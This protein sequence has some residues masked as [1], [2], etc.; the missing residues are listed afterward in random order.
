[1]L[2][3]RVPD[4]SLPREALVQRVTDGLSGR[5]V[6][7]VAGAG[8][9]KSTLLA[10]ALEGSPHPWVWLGCDERMGD[11]GVFVSHIAAGIEQR[12]PG[13]GAQ[14][15]SAGPPAALVAA[16]GNEILAT[17][18]EDLI[19]A[20][21]DAHLLR[22]TPGYEVLSLL[23]HDL[24][25]H[26][27]LAIA[28]RS[29]LLLPLA[30]M[31][32]AD[33]VREFKE[34]DLVLTSDESRDLLHTRGVDLS[35]AA[36]RQL[37]KRTE[38]WITGIVLAAQ[39]GGRTPG[40]GG[41]ADPGH[42]FDYMAEEVFH[43]QP[44]ELQDFLLQTA[45][46]ERF[47]VGVASA[48]AGV[49]AKPVI[50]ELAAR[51]LFVLRLDA[52]G[53]M[54]RYHHLFA[55][56][57]R[58]RLVEANVDLLERHRRAAD[59]WRE[60]G[61]L[62]DAVHHYLEAGAMEAALDALEPIVESMVRTPEAARVQRWLDSIPESL[63]SERPALLL[64]R[65]TLYFAQGQY[66]R[67]M[68]ALEHA[69]DRLTAAGD[70]ERAAAAIFALGRAATT[71]GSS[72]S[73]G[74]ALARKY[75]PRIDPSARMLPAARLT[76]AHLHGYACRYDRTEDELAAAA[77]L[78]AAAGIAVFD[79]YVALMRAFIVEHPRGRSDEALRDI[80]SVI[81]DLER[82]EDE[83]TLA[84]LP[85]AFAY[86]AIV[87]ADIGRYSD[88][89]LDARRVV[90]AAER[91][92]MGPV[93]VPV[94]AWIRFAALAGLARWE[95]LEAEIERTAGL[96]ASL[97]GAVR[98][99]LFHTASARLAAF[100]GDTDEVISQVQSA[101]A[102]VLEHDYRY[103][104]AM[105]SVDL[106][107][108]AF[109]V[110]ADGLAREMA[111][112]A[113]DAARKAKGSLAAL[114]AAIVSAVVCGDDAGRDHLERALRLTAR[115]GYQ[116]IWSR[117][118]R[119]VAAPL[120]VRA[121]NCGLGPR[122]A[123]ARVAAECGREVFARCVE[124]V[125]SPVGRAELAALAME[126][127]DVEIASLGVLARDD[128]PGIREAAAKS[129]QVILSRPR[130]PMRIVTLGGLA[131][132]RGESPVPGSAFVRRKARG[133]L[134]AL[135][136]ARAPVHR[137]IL[138]EW[139]WPDLPPDRGLAALYVTLHDLRRALEPGLGRGTSSSLVVVDG[140]AY[141]LV[142][143]DGDSWDVAHFLELA[144]WASAEGRRG[145]LEGLHAAESA[146]T[147]ELLPEWPF[148]EW[149]R[150]LRAEVEQARTLVLERLAAALLAADRPAEAVTR[151]KALVAIDGEYEA[152]HRGLMRAYAQ[153]GETALALRQYHACR[154]RLRREQGT[155]PGVETRQLYG[156]LLAAG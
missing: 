91:R 113:V 60:E 156:E 111:E 124:E 120:L 53:A 8:Y 106:A 88:S 14:L 54:F 90:D 62:A 108:A 118:H 125:V 92:G 122:G 136:C 115:H 22:G 133:L 6:A 74:L 151:Y 98:G 59:A 83:D 86:R 123:A 56:F 61:G 116:Q 65:A 72:R 95:E 129:E 46:L 21:D 69:L 45:I 80:D 144:R 57:L 49:D 2:P 48:M 147:G 55:E 58:R 44:P 38:G 5:L 140:E 66:E 137:E 130:P 24:P 25:P 26:I 43:R 126:G 76:L 70:H 93:A 148:E 17:V 10:Q 7:I 12:L 19:L 28:G 33:E 68:G 37:H 31:R 117:R 52:E 135:A 142:L 27:H 71:A 29:N 105:V 155:E 23:L 51:H 149:A 18:V 100:R 42:L 103:E 32:A 119:D 97:G 75:V 87:L 77:A 1:M 110:G 112:A 146:Y 34:E 82:R 131:V 15:P 138:L 132:W 104:E 36:V 109:A 3:P 73:R 152:W 81:A 139:F 16:L 40:I 50:D 4:G 128:D 102:G 84:Q 9:G 96:F 11:A 141:R 94:S 30:R 85:Y 20:I 67:A 64:A 39:T 121:L 150:P 154:A 41:A 47:S 107:F 13:F 153:A 101:R 99:Y 89:L 79:R 63:W 35:D 134:A 114:R 143:Q 127:S 78:P 145:A